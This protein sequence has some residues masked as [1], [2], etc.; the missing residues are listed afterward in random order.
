MRNFPLLW[1]RALFQ[2]ELVLWSPSEG[3][4]QPNWLLSLLL[5]LWMRKKL[6]KET[7]MVHQ[8]LQ[9]SSPMRRPEMNQ[10]QVFQ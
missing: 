1:M 4:L 2:K 8:W 9:S 10:I 5:L 3:R 7:V 6:Q